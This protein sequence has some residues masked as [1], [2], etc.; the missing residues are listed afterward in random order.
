MPQESESR[1]L[2]KV[3]VRLPDG[4]RDRLKDAAKAN[5]RSMNA[6]IVARLENSGAETMR[7]RFAMATLTGLCVYLRQY[8]PELIAGWAY[9]LADAMLAQREKR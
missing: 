9:Q 8:E 1:A 7:D 4:M 5:N 6:E 3:I 2:D